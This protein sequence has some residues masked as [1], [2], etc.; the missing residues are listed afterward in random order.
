VIAKE[1]LRA[2]IQSQ[3]KLLGKLDLSSENIPLGKIDEINTKN[4][5][6]TQLRSRLTGLEGKSSEHYFK[7]YWKQFPEY[8]QPVK[9]ENYKALSPLNNLLNLG[10]EVLKGDVYKA[11]LN[12]HLDPYLGYLHSIQYSKPSM[13]CDLQ[14]PFRVIIEEFL[15]DFQH[16]LDMSS[17]Q[18]HGK[19][20]FLKEN[21]KF[22]MIKNLNEKLN[23]RIPYNRRNNTKRTKTR[24]A[25]KDITIKLAQYIRG[26]LPKPD[27]FQY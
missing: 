21:E 16:Q 18:K 19:R 11:V 10:Y 2:R 7:E 26:K 3:I 8:L 1:I 5:T 25:I 27:L 22:N 6:I 13:V 9:R 15:L 14:E 12:A 24:T 17:F 23:E 4:K 20:N